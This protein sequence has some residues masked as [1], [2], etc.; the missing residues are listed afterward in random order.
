MAPPARPG[1]AL[2][3]LARAAYHRPT[4]AFGGGTRNGA[5]PRRREV[6]VRP[7]R[8]RTRGLLRDRSC[9]LRDLLREKRGALTSEYTILVGV[10]GLVFVFALVAVGPKL[11]RHFMSTRT[12]LAS[13][14]P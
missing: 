7:P 9:A 4:M 11:V 13:P 6:L 14:F 10:V 12:L 3:E 2:Q 1:P 8:E 5:P